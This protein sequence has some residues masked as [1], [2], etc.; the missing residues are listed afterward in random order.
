MV[1]TQGQT[2]GVIERDRNPRN[3]RY[4]VSHLFTTKIAGQ[5][6]EEIIVFKKLSGQLG[7]DTQNPGA[8]LGLC[9]RR[10][11]RPTGLGSGSA[12]T[13]RLPAKPPGLGRSAD[14]PDGA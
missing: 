14:L 5:F 13:G 8:R 6:G 3:K 11:P 7:I 4:I 9:L 10:A 2:C 1:R 12:P